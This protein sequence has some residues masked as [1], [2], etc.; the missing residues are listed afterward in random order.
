[1]GSDDL[2][3]V[4]ANADRFDDEQKFIDL[5]SAPVWVV[6]GMS[7]STDGAR[8]IIDRRTTGDPGQAE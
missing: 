8:L 3:V 5:L 1:M 7:P 2:A 6:E 4:R